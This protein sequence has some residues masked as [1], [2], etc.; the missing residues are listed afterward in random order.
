[1]SRLDRAGT[2]LLVIDVQ[3]RLVPAIDQH[4]LL[5]QNIERL[6]RGARVLELP[7]LVTEQ[8]PQGLGHTVD[9]VRSALQDAQAQPAIEKATF[10]AWRS[11]EFQTALRLL[12]KK[13]AIVSGIESHVC[14]YQTVSDLLE[15][16][17]AVTVVDDAVSSRTQRNQQIGVRR[18]LAEGAS[19]SSTEMVLFELTRTSGSD[20]FRAISKLVK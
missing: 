9:P 7:M 1:M 3:E 18:M 20:E 2:F 8:Y 10:S 16:G 15:N 14:V 17:F 13:Q 5:L 11:A 12:Q 4:V 19:L 6:I